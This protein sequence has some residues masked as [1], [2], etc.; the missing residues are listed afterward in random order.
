MGTFPN[1]ADPARMVRADLTAAVLFILAAADRPTGA[2]VIHERLLGRGFQISEPTVGRLLRE[3]DRLGYT[4]SQGR[5]GR[6]LTAKGRQQLQRLDDTTSRDQ[7]AKQLLG[8]IRSDTLPDVI[9]AL[10]ARRG[11]EREMARLAA[12]RIEDDE[13]A[14]LRSYGQQNREGDECHE[15]LHDLLARSCRSPVLQSI[16]QILTRDPELSRLLSRVCSETEVH[17]G[18]RFE[19]RIVE[20]L[21]RRD[22]DEAE[23][24]VAGHIDDLLAAVKSSWDSVA[25]G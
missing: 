7:N 14:E 4:S 22:P 21:E 12:L 19:H 6:L 10:T 15:G 16:H 9:D 20:A 3:F 2:S 8:S 23:A 11:V 25:A 5:L 17:A 13:L 1:A 24:A 18:K